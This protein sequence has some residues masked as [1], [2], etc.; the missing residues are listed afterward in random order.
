[1]AANE[2]TERFV[3]VSNL[4]DILLKRHAPLVDVSPVNRSYPVVTSSRES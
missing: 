4:A 1:M 3:W 2:M